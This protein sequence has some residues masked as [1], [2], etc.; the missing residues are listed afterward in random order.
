MIAPTDICNYFCQISS[1][2][3][4][5]FQKRNIT[6]HIPIINTCVSGLRQRPHD[7]NGQISSKSVQQFQMRRILKGFPYINRLYESHGDLVLR[8]FD[9]SNLNK[10]GNR[11]KRIISVKFGIPYICKVSSKSVSRF[12]E[13]VVYFIF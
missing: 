7:K 4:Q 2:S 6:P 5:R 3:V 13:A 10:L 9:T 11:Y 12:R 8:S 1:V